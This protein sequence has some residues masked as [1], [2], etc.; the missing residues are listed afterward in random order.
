MP[1]TQ[2]GS[3]VTDF[4]ASDVSS[5]TTS[6]T[7]AA[8]TNK[9]LIACISTDSAEE[10]LSV[11][12]NGVNLTKAVDS[13]RAGARRTTIWY[14]L[15][16]PEITADMVATFDGTSGSNQVGVTYHSWEN[17]DLGIPISNTAANF[18]DSGTVVTVTVPSQ[19]S[20]LC[21]DSINNDDNT[22]D[23]TVG[24]G[25]TELSDIEITGDFRAGSSRK[26]GASPDVTMTWTF[27]VSDD[28]VTAAISLR[29]NDPVP[30]T[31]RM[32]MVLG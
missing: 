1:I 7:Q 13:L 3:T 32:Y 11:T 20:D 9:I 21:I 5:I 2:V 27:G 28:W 8:G 22:S 17:V 12:F 16:P 19:E 29:E 30:S 15:D 4:V 14:L 18:G 6:Y 23:P 24:A 26:D 31:Q 25:Q 10:H